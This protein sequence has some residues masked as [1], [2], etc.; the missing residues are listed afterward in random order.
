MESADPKSDDMTGQEA[1]PGNPE[2]MDPNLEYSQEDEEVVEQRE[3][4]VVV[5]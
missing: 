5:S 1:S 4:E 2:S 3:E